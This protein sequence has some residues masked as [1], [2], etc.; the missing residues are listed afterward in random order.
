M[1]T[2]V[3]VSKRMIS[4]DAL[5]GFT[6]AGMILVNV[7]GSWE[8]IYP[9][10]RHAA[11][12]GLTLADL[13]FPFFLFIVGA[14]IVLALGKRMEKGDSK[15][16]M[17]GK[18]LYRTLVIFLLGVL[19]N[20][21]SADFS[22][23]LR[24]AGVLQRIALCYLMASLLF[25]YAKRWVMVGLA[26]FIVLGY[27]ML[28]VFVPVPGE[29]VAILS[30]EVNWAAWIDGQ[31]LPG[32]RYFGHWDPEGILSTFPAL[33]N[34]LLGIFTMQL[35]QKNA[36]HLHQIKILLLV[37]INLIVF[38]WLISF[39]FPVNKNVWSSSFV[40]LTSGM[41]ALLW[42]LLVYVVDM[43]E[44][45]KWVKPG[46]IFGSNAITAYVLHYLF[47]YPLGRIKVGGT[48]FHQLFMDALGSFLSPNLTS[49][50]WAIFYTF[51][52]FLPIWWMYRKKVFV[53]I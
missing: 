42:A 53:K 31:L 12:N 44:H 46:I 20:W 41:A 16:A 28:N 15:R 14:S 50:C 1:N 9:P 43:K 36:L 3:P 17:L 11:F 25:L 19:L 2:N 7:P 38:G 18:I 33:V 4:L 8:H 39:T 30:P 13:V 32:N 49:L 5:R 34:T 26:V 35:L 37:G 29:G 21:L 51:L 24:I 52:C 48:S 22:F 45:S 23:P 6:I 47:H 10:L 27:W 40:L